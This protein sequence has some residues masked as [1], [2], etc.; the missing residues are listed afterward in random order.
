MSKIVC[1]AGNHVIGDGEQIL[2]LREGVEL[3]VLTLTSDDVG[4][5]IRSA[6][7]SELFPSPVEGTAFSGGMHMPK[8]D[9]K[10]T[11]SVVIKFK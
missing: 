10:T 2:F 1:K 4:I 11:A 8:G 5:E 9:G 7:F 6:H 3:G